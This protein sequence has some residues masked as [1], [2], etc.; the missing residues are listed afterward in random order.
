M[1]DPQP[2][3]EI[4]IS[5]RTASFAAGATPLEAIR[6][7]MPALADDALCVMCG[8][9]S[10]A[11]NEPLLKSCALKPLT[12]HNEEGRRVYERSL[13]FL[14]LLSVRRLFPGKRIR[15][16]NS[17]GYGVYLRVIDEEMDFKMVRPPLL[18]RKPF[19]VAF[20]RGYLSLS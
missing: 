8:G 4:T 12:Y 16:L 1:N 14:L 17:V 6:R 20:L 18:S 3:I 11:L 7:L 19:E 5:G 10:L 13:R 15:I 9:Q 2:S